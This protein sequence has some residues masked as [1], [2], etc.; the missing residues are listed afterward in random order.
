M[1]HHAA[2]CGRFADHDAAGCGRGS[3]RGA[4][5][6]GRFADHDGGWAKAPPLRNRPTDRGTCGRLGCWGE[7]LVADRGAVAIRPHH[8][9]RMS[10]WWQDPINGPCRARTGVGVNP[11]SARRG[12][13]T[14]RSPPRRVSI[15]ARSRRVVICDPH[16]PRRVVGSR[17][18]HHAPRRH[19]GSQFLIPNSQFRADG[20]RRRLVMTLHRVPIESF[21][22]RLHILP[23]K[24][25]VLGIVNCEL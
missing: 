25:F 21:F 8:H 16:D 22:Q 14:A 1:I 5:G 7:R 17:M 15:R 3:I 12:S 9:P 2:G 19:A 18:A 4:A 10:R 24:R 13:S 23:K 11:P 20:Y 6:I